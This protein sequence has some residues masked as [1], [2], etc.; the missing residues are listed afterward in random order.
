MNI[1]RMSGSIRICHDRGRFVRIEP[2]RADRD[3][4][5]SA[6]KSREDEKEWSRAGQSP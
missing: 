3:V 2:I 6:A 4:D 5:S 1:I